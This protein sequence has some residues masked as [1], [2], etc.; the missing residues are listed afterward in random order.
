MTKF[1]YDP[2]FRCMVKYQDGIEKG[3]LCLEEQEF[4]ALYFSLWTLLQDKRF[5]I[6]VMDA[7][8]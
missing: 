3:R 8:S 4:D 2:E 7:N 5:S 6:E 1:E